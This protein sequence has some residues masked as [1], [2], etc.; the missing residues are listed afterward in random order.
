MSE[1]SDLPLR[2]ILVG[3]ALQQLKRLPDHAVDC[4]ITSPPYFSM[5][6]YNHP[7]QLGAEANVEAW[8]ANVATVCAELWRVLTPSGALWLNLGDGYSRHSGEGGTKKSLLLGPQRVALRLTRS[9]WLLRNQVIWAKTNPMPS[10]VRDRFTTTHEFVYFF[11]KQSKYYF[12]LDAVREEP[13]SSTTA[14][15]RPQQASYPPRRAVPALGGG[16][17]ARINLNEGLA[18]LRTAGRGSHPLGKNPGDIWRVAT[19][20]YRDA[21]FATFPVELVRRPLLTTCPQRLCTTCGQPWRRAAQMLG[22]RPLSTGRLEA[23]CQCRG[24]SR[25]GIVLDPFIGSGTV[26]LAAATYNR[27]WIGIELN[28]GYAQLA[29]RRIANWCT[30]QDIAKQF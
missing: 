14:R 27:D 28:P 20:N 4:V 9:G 23:A 18:A 25:A 22:S 11:T 24:E 19:A 16:T 5:R 7:G 21:H 26:A 3:D 8:A 6:D 12:D 30:Q 17:T 15:G 1:S 13:L 29:R 10:S 2:R